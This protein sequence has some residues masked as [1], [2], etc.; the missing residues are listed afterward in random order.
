M[1]KMNNPLCGLCGAPLKFRRWS[2]RLP[3]FSEALADCPDGCGC[4]QIRYF[5]GK[6]T[7]EPYQI[8]TKAQKRKRGS[9]RLSDERKAA[10]VAIYG[11]V[12][13]FLDCAP[14]VCMSLQ[15]KH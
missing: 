6:P 1:V 4:W 8:K 11:G 10:I 3:K 13:E 12:Q 7:S 2:D 5:D 9:W 14:L 15:I